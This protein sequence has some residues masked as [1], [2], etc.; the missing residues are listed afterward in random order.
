MNNSSS[1][2]WKTIFRLKECHTFLN[3]TT[4]SFNGA[5]PTPAK[6]CAMGIRACR[7]NLP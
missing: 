7:K 1:I 4:S 5:D 2:E 6:K 3:P